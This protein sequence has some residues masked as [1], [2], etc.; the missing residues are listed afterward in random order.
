MTAT[1]TDIL[2][3]PVLKMCSRDLLIAYEVQSAVYK[4]WARDSID[5]FQQSEILSR[6]P[7]VFLEVLSCAKCWLIYCRS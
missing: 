6:V 2:C 1:T 4:R 3:T 5:S 7:K